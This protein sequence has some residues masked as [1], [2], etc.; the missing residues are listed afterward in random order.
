ME[1][2]GLIIDQFSITKFFEVYLDKLNSMKKEVNYTSEIETIKKNLII[3][4]EAEEECIK[5]LTD[6]IRKDKNKKLEEISLEYKNLD[7]IINDEEMEIYDNNNNNENE[8]N[9]NDY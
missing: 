4:K 2:N 1:K 7:N 3:S 6:L 8:N 9:E 5:L